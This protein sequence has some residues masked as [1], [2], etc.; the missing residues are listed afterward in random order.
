MSVVIFSAFLSCTLSQLGGGVLTEGGGI[1]IGATFL[2]GVL[3]AAQYSLIQVR[4]CWSQAWV[5]WT[6]VREQSQLTKVLY[7]YQNNVISDPW[8]HKFNQYCLK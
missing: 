6:Q 2:N 7:N 8:V 3:Q 4:V 5:C 1:Q